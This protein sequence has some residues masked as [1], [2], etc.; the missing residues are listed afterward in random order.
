MSLIGIVAAS[1]CNDENA[2]VG[3][4][5]HSLVG[6]PPCSR[7]P[8]LDPTALHRRSGP[9]WNRVEL[10]VGA[11]VGA[12]FSCRSSPWEVAGLAVG[13]VFRVHRDFQGP[14]FVNLALAWGWSAT[15]SPS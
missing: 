8:I 9:V 3:G 6:I 11:F 2:R 5:I 7:G 10:F 14:A 1:E 13:L 4:G 15:E 12:T